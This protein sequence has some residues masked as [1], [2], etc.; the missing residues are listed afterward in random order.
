MGKRGPKGKP[1]PPEKVEQF[2]RYGMQPEQIAKEM[3]VHLS[4]FYEKQK[5]NPEITEA[6]KRGR[7]FF[8]EWVKMTRAQQVLS[9]YDRLVQEGNPAAVIFGMK[10]IVGL[11]EQMNV[12]HSVAKE[13]T[14]NDDRL[15]ELEAKRKALQDCEIDAQFEKEPDTI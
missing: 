11:S 12:T 4:T 9:A 1:I 3:N 5:D 2:A 8:L 13:I 6:Y 15:A 14:Q 7:E 10:A